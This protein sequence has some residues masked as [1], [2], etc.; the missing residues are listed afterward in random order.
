MVAGAA[1][2]GGA[3]ALALAACGGAAPGAAPELSKQPVTIRAFIG[4]VDAAGMDSWGPE[5]AAPYKERRPNVTLELM[6]QAMEVNGIKTGGTLGVVEKLVA[7][8]AGGDPPDIDDL[9]RAASWQVEQGLLDDQMDGFVKRDKYDTKQFNQKE[10]N[11]RAVYKGKVWQ[12][13]FK[14]GGN[15]LV[16]VCNRD[17]FLSEGI[18][19]PGIDPKRPW[20][21]EEFVQT[22]RRLT[23]RSGSTTTQFGLM[24]Y[25][26]HLGSWP[27]LWQTDWVSADGKTITCDSPEMLDCYTKFGDLFTRDHVIPRPGEASQLFGSGNMF[28]NK[29]AAMTIMSSGS[30]RTYVS[31]SDLTDVAFAPMPKVKIST[32]DVNAHSLG[33]I[34]GSKHQAEAWEAIKYL[35]D[36]SRLARFTNR[37]PAILKDV[38]P[39]A[40]GDLKR[41]PQADVNV[42]QQALA[43]MV[44]QVNL[45]GHKWQDDM[46]RVLN[47]AMEGMLLGKEAPVPLL[48]RLKPELQAIA[49]RP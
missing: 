42:V 1:A 45:S 10:F 18:P 20:N 21:W 44:P 41:F 26:W 17:S 43:T 12:I 29:K 30:W 9:P 46:L 31:N 11:H 40:E 6:S 27:L 5:I 32:P 4:G 33:I 47:P 36:G 37:L 25:G 24:N 28:L 34:R 8:I 19:I 48:K 3:L 14:L 49:D 13:P 16:L 15:T 22:L 23:K 38:Q 35:N 7:L 39:W 2:T